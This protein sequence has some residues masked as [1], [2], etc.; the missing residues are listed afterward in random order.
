VLIDSSLTSVPEPCGCGVA[1]GLAS[2]PDGH[3]RVGQILG[4]GRGCDEPVDPL[5]DQVDGRVVLALDD[6]TRHPGG[7][8]LGDDESES[9]AGGWH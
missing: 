7:S 8:R 4:V 2:P 5:L 3:D 6:H 9:L 1:Q